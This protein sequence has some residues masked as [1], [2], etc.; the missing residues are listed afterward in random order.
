MRPRNGAQYV[1]WRVV[2]PCKSQPFSDVLA[3]YPERRL[4]PQINRRQN[5]VSA[6]I[7]FY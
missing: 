4:V 7:L 6:I 3:D 5:R 2:V 1:L